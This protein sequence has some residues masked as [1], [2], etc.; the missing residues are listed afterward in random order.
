MPAPLAPGSTFEL[1]LD[2]L[3]A[4]GEAL[5]RVDGYPVFVPYGA[6]G[7]LVRARVVS[8]KPAYARAVVEAV[9]TPGPDRAE[10]PCPV[11]GACGGCAWQHLSYPAQLAAKRV[12]VEDALRRLGG[13]EPA[14]LVA[15]T[16]AAHS[17]WHYRNK[18]HWAIAKAGG[19][20]KVGLYA[21]RSHKVVDAPT[22][23]IQ[24][25]GNNEM[26]AAARQLLSRFHWPLYDE[27]TGKGLVRSVF[28]KTGH[29]TG[30]TMLGV[31]TAS[32]RLPAEQAFVAAAREA[33]PG[34][35]TLVQNVHPAAG[36]KLMGDTTRV[37]FGPGVVTEEVNGL[38]YA[39]SARSFFQVNSGTVEALYGFAA[40]ACGLASAPRVVDAYSGTGAIALALAKG[41]AAFVTGIEIVEAATSDAEASALRNGL[42]HKT[43]FVT[44]AVEAALPELVA[45]GLEADVVVLDPPRKGCEEAVLEAV[46]KLGVPRVVYVSCD[47]ATLARD[48]GRFAGLG[49]R[50]TRVQPV[51]M[52]P[53]TAHVECVA[54]LER[55]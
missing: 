19:E 27:R 37:L 20:W 4:G 5:G 51:D 13:L 33:L 24:H 39:I 31:V 22:C 43:R 40:E 3:V 17:P 34:L 2:T 54:T 14:G 28:A 48:L 55:A 52:F 53:Q 26:L 38:T 41:G 29:R 32:P 44:G 35:T 36:N 46:A 25:A 30:E 21:P 18:V 10:P 7:D 8:A 23:A 42:A 45:G 9:L 1:T 12:L 6:P 47:P 11:F 15:P 49:Y 16:Q 50:T